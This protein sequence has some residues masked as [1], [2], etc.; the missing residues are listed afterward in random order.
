MPSILILSARY[1]IGQQDIDVSQYINEK[2]SANYGMLDFPVKVLD[3]HLRADNQIMPIDEAALIL[4]PGRLTINYGD[5]IGAFHTVTYKYGE[6]VHI[7]ERSALG[8]LLQKPQQILWDIGLTA[9]KGQFFFVVVFGWALVVMWTYTQWQFLEEAFDPSK[10]GPASTGEYTEDK[11]GV[12]GQWVMFAI[13]KLLSF[14]DGVN[15]ITVG[16][17]YAWPT[18]VIFAVLSGLA[19]VAGFFFELMIWFTAVSSIP[20][21]PKTTT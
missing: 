15:K 19:P 6:Q 7:G 10:R 16:W 13:Y 11:Y 1:V 14:M 4:S 21:V 12:L 5:P 8:K 2:L 3:D 20:S 17:P 9:A 18:K